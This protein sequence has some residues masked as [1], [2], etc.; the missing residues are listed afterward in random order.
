MLAIFPS[1]N[2]FLKLVLF[3][4]QFLHLFL[5]YFH[6]LQSSIL[7]VY[8]VLKHKISTYKN[9]TWEDRVS[10]EAMGDLTDVK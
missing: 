4:L 9:R 7:Q 5:G 3:S 10:T 6:V 1:T 8:G 2:Q